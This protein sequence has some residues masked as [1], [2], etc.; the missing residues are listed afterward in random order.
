MP[1]LQLFAKNSMPRVLQIPHFMQRQTNAFI[2][3]RIQRC[4]LFDLKRSVQNG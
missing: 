1:S 4:I 2:F 3:V